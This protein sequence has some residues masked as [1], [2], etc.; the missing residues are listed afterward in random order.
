MKTIE[1]KVAI[2]TGASRGIGRAIAERLAGDGAKVIVN[3]AG[4][5]DKAAEVVG[6]IEAAGGQ[7]FAV[8]ADV[9]SRADVSRLFAETEKKFGQPDILVNNAGVFLMKPLIETTDDEFDKIFAT[10]VRGVFFCLQEAARRIGD[11][12]RIVNLSS[13]ATAASHPGGSVYAASK[14]AVE[15]FTRVLAKE[16]GAR[17][18]TVN[19]V[20]PGATETD[21]MPDA[22]R[23]IAPK[24]TALGRLGQP[25]DIADV[26]AFLASDAARWITG[27]NIGANGGLG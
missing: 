1:G 22:A 18:I 24:M 4:S 16:L 21:M 3:Y 19:S 23:E 9:G 25:A 2:V 13:V 8:Q 5:R 17:Q 27:Q 6:V 10:N 12:G 7:A 26:V 14:A 11:N 15:Q 20:S